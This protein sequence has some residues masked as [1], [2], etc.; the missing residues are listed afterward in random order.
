[1][2]EGAIFGETSSFQQVSDLSGL[3]SNTCPV[4]EIEAVVTAPGLGFPKGT[5]CVRL[6]GQA[7]QGGEDALVPG[8]DQMHEM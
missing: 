3:V 4:Y 6:L 5:S 8:V 7:C 2:G 1:M